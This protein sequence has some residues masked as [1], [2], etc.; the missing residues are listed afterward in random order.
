[1]SDVKRAVRVAEEVRMALSAILL[2]GLKDPR[3]GLLT[4]TDVE[5]TDDLRQAKIYLSIY[6]KDA[7]GSLV[8][9]RKA[10]SFLRREL[11]HR[12][13]LRFTP[14]LKFF[15]DEAIGRGARI[16]QL[17]RGATDV[18]GPLPAAPVDTGRTDK[19][20]G[21]QELGPLPPIPPPPSRK[22]QKP[23]KARKPGKLTRMR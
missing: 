9:I 13:P 20:A 22:R 10:A 1:M 4:I 16:E 7:Q 12:V 8:A 15:L 17:L 5:M 6:G 21:E 18:S 19:S 23:G 14:E 11:G 2:E 3:I